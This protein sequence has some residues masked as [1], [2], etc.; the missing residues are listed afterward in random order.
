M[1]AGTE[2]RPSGIANG[3]RLGLLIGIM[4]VTL[5]VIWNYVTAPISAVVGI[6][7]ASEYIVGSIVYGAVISMIY[8]PAVSNGANGRR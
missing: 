7:E 8:R 1:Y 4:V 2:S 5:A 6:A 3:A